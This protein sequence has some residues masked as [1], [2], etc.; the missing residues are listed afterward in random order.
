MNH[1]FDI[2]DAKKYGLSEAVILSNFQFWIAKNHANQRHFYDGRTWTYNSIKAMEELFPYMSNGQIRRAV[3]S[4]VQQGVLVR[5]NYNQSPYDR[6]TWFG[7]SDGYLAEMELAKEKFPFGKTDKCT[8]T[9]INTDNPPTPKGGEPIGF[10]NFWNAWPSSLRKQ[11]KGKCLEA[12][13][14]NRTEMVAVVVL[15][16][17]QRMAESKEWMKN[18]GEFIPAP[19]V[20]LNQRRWEGA[21]TNAASADPFAGAI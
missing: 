9:D 16:H 15:I 3:D 13:K 6:T 1:N 2:D 14:K 7:F 4:L 20:Y 5:G 11:S 8:S 10:I 18:G 17:V 19:L 12:W 21:E